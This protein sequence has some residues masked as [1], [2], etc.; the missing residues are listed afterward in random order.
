MAGLFQ[1]IVQFWKPA[2]RERHR[3]VLVAGKIVNMTPT[4]ARR[5]RELRR[6]KATG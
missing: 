4:Q 1:K 6:V 2:E 5:Y 3:K